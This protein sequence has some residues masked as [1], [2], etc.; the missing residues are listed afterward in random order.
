MF[1][2]LEA[3]KRSKIKFSHMQGKKGYNV[4]YLNIELLF[5]S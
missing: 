2:R 1:L 4:K 5:L 3:K